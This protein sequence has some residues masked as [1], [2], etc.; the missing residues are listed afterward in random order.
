MNARA[1]TLLELVIVIAILGILAAIALPRLS[2][3]GQGAKA[4]T[5]ARNL[6]HLRAAIDRYTA[7]H[8]AT[9]PQDGYIEEQLTQYSN[10][11][12]MVS[13]SPFD[14]ALGPYLSE[15][16]PVPVGDNAGARSIEDADG[17]GVGWIYDEDQITIRANATGNDH[18]GK[19]WADY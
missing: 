11:A 4:S 9:P 7:E 3:A 6:Q 2:S 12:G 17:P 5:L 13:A 8:N 1:F 16:P 10:H 18:L 19:P 15:I 14:G